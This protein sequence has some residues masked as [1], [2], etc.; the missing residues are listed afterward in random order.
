MKENDIFFQELEERTQIFLESLE[1][2]EN[3]FSFIPANEG[4]L[5]AGNE[6]KLGFSCYALKINYMLGYWEK[7][8]DKNKKDWV[9]FINSFQ[10]NLEGFPRYSFIDEGYVKNMDSKSIN[11]SVRDTIKQ[12]LT[13]LNIK[14]YETREE[15]IKTSVRAESKQAISTLYQVGARNE[16]P[17]LD[18]PKEK[19]LIKD[20]LEEL[21]WTHPW[22]SGAQFSGLCV[23]VE[24]QNPL[25]ELKKELEL[26]SNRL[27]NKDSG[28]YYLGKKP[29]NSELV[30]GAMKVVTG[31]D[32]L[33]IEIHYPEKLIDVCLDIK[34]NDEGCDLVDI[35]YVLYM[36]SL[37]TNYKRKE[38]I[39][40]V[41]SLIPVIKKHYY[42]DLGGFS[43]YLDKSQTLY[44]GVKFSKGFNTP[45]IHGTMLLLWALSMIRAITDEDSSW[46]VLKP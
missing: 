34:P 24:T 42:K 26:F 7:L 1:S 44:Y 20:F 46:N 31:L 2:N 3:S 23:F 30:N 33:N 37:Y 18:F 39:N 27:V 8:N 45:D 22:H 21:D 4:L 19:D 36:C 40:Y 41:N 14:R 9:S 11:S 12:A 29:N 32:W 16:H 5:K 17:Y 25:P 15:K 28:F 13:Q 38:I 6:L 35:V 43:Y 10:K